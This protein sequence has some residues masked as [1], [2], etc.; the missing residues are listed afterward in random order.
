MFSWENAS[1]QSHSMNLIHSSEVRDHEKCIGAE[2]RVSLI[3]SV[4]KITLSYAM[5]S[6]VICISSL[7]LGQ[8]NHIIITRRILRIP[9]SNPVEIPYLCMSFSIFLAGSM[10]GMISKVS[11]YFI[12]LVPVP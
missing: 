12:V 11:L 8:D 5:R 2:G 6:G 10:V 9:D 1:F 4:V 7:Q 3:E